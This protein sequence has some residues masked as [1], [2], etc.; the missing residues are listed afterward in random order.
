MKITSQQKKQ[1]QKVGKKYKLKL[2]LLHGSYATGKACKESDLD[3][4]VLGKKPIAFE[5]LLELHGEIASIFGDHKN[6]ELDLK[7]LH[8]ADPLFCYQV[9]K[10][11]QLLY[12]SSFDYDEFRVYAFKAYYDAKDLF[13]LEHKLIKKYQDYLNRKYG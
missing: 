10:N 13:N 11:S 4:A 9:A 6:R 7:S 1:L 5:A 2:I 8:Q 12:G 3:I